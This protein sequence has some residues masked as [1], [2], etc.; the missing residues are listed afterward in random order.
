MRPNRKWCS[1]RSLGTL[2]IPQ[3]TLCVKAED[4]SQEPKTN[5][6]WWL[7][8]MFVFLAFHRMSES[9]LLAVDKY[10]SSLLASG[11]GGREFQFPMPAPSCSRW[12]R[13]LHFSAWP[14]RGSMDSEESLKGVSLGPW[15]LWLCTHSQLRFTWVLKR[16]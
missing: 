14:Q 5:A 13:W 1:P 15:V 3:V 10:P 16:L 2:L 7:A 11:G 6:L 9:E 4:G 8:G 12:Y